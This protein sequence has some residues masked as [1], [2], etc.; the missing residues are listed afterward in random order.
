MAK[1]M[2]AHYILPIRRFSTRYMR[3]GRIPVSAFIWT[4][5]WYLLSLLFTYTIYTIHAI[6][7]WKTNAQVLSPPY[8][9]LLKSTPMENTFCWC[10]AYCS[11]SGAKGLRERYASSV[12]VL[13]MSH[14]W[15]RESLLRERLAEW[16]I[17][18]LSQYDSPNEKMLFS[19]K[20]I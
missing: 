8:S 14:S 1:P 17:K 11:W 12:W 15:E 7:T 10:Q 18:W 16:L 9:M 3:M 2:E 13:G 20:R 19:Q 5:S 4:K 6:P